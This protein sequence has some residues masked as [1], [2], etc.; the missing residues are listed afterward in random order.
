MTPTLTIKQEKFCQAY[1]RLGVEFDTYIEVFG[2]GK[3]KDETIQKKATAL[4]KEKVVKIRVKE[5][6]KHLG[7]APTLYREEY[8]EQA[9]KLCLLGATDKDIADFFEVC[10]ATIN[11]WKKE[12][13]KFLESI[14]AGKKTA[15]MEVATSLYKT[16]QD[17]TVIEQVAFKTKKI[18]YNDSGKRVEEE[19]IEIVDVAKAIPADFRSQ[20]F[21]L[22]NR[23]SDQWRDKQ[24]VDHSG[25]ISIPVIQ[26]LKPNE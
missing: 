16:T 2:R 18:S 3:M 25:E 15:D 24:E 21:W 23:K 10:E 20:Q 4:L 5:L 6:K 26:I 11:N 19:V 12:Y 7:G 8:D 13:P 14:R 17:R 22:K 1:I 9:Y